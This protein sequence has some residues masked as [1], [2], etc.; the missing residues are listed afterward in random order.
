MV[1]TG[2]R[3]WREYFFPHVCM[4]L[5]CNHSTHLSISRL[6]WGAGPLPRFAGRETL[7]RWGSTESRSTL[8]GEENRRRVSPRVT[9]TF[10]VASVELGVL[11]VG[12]KR[13]TG[14]SPKKR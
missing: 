10:P 12:Q 4:M 6:C 1:S 3:W 2:G 8:Q 5:T 11:P 9:V 13:K 7:K 14:G